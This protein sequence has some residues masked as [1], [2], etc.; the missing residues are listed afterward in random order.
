[1]NLFELLNRSRVTSASGVPLWALGCFRRRS[2]AFFDGSTDFTTLVI[3]LQSRGL[4]F[5]LRLAADRPRPRNAGA[6]ADCSREEL[7]RLAQAEGGI[8]RTTAHDDPATSS[9]VFRWDDWVAFQPYAKWPEPGLLR[10]VGDCLIEFAPSGAYVEEWRHQSGGTGSLIG[11]RLV[12]ERDLDTGAVLHRGGGLLV[13]GRHAG[14][15]R[16]RAKPLAADSR[17]AELVKEKPQD[18][19]LLAAV[20]DFEASYAERA[21]GGSFVVKASTLPWREGGALVELDGFLPGDSGDVLVQRVH[22]RGVPLERRFLVDT[23]ESNCPGLEATA[24]SPEGAAWLEAERDT[25]CASAV[26]KP[27]SG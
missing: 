15:V 10:R 6:L 7:V 20:F 26:R 24:V 11:L 27:R 25:L 1:M 13:C 16:G 5:D 4:T 23:L 17:A 14:W 18:R 8:A 19:E 9:A 3:W 22:D 12:E 21:P 2:I